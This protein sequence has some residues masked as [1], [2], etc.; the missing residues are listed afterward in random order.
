MWLLIQS[1]R[2]SLVLSVV[3]CA[4]P[5]QIPIPSSTALSFQA[6]PGFMKLQRQEVEQLIVGRTLKLQFSDT[7]FSTYSINSSGYVIARIE[8]NTDDGRWQID[9]NGRLC[10]VFRLSG[11]I[12]RSIWKK[13]DGSYEIFARNGPEGRPLF[14]PLSIY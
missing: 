10:T 7:A 5:E 2:L 8:Q 12:C 11:S 13:D 14:W 3:A 9:S 4:T 1:L 6:R